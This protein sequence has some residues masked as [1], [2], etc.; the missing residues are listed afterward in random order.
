VRGGGRRCSGTRSAA[1][2]EERENGKG[3]DDGHHRPRL[4]ATP[5]AGCAHLL[6]PD[7]RTSH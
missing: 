4:R 7:A 6:P 5:R 2:G 3:A 1:G